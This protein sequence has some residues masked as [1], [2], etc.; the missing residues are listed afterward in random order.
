MAIEPSRISTM[1]LGDACEDHHGLYEII[2]SL[3]THHPDT[4]EDVKL[5]VAQRAVSELAN[6]GFISLYQTSDAGRT[7][8]SVPEPEVQTVIG[9]PESWRP[10][11]DEQARQYWFAATAAGEEAYYSGE[12]QPRDSA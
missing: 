6:L 11:G 5:Q 8:V 4:S 12:V 3:N 2:W 1:I 10:P 7:F 9:A